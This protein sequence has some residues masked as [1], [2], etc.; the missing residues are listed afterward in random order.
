MREQV[1]QQLIDLNRGFYRGF[2]APFAATRLR[3]QPGVRRAVELI[4]RDA[5]VLDLGCGTGELASALRRA[6]HT[7]GYV[8]IDA[9]AELLAIAR[10]RHPTLADR[11]RED[12]L[13]SPGWES[14]LV[15]PFARITAFAVLHHIPSERLRSEVARSIGELLTPGGM[16]ILSVWN[17]N[18]S[19]RLRAR[20]V[21]WPRVGLTPADVD[22]GDAL[23]GW[24]QGGS[25]VRYVH[26]FGPHE[27]DGLAASAGLT[28]VDRYDSDGEGGRLGH[29]QV[30]RDPDF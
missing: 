11:F 16:V 12:D 30:W 6:G 9:S 5:D 10:S 27:L 17:F 13:A 29:Y 19:E 4:P 2:A 22:P 1:V 14:R 24:R 28:V 8:G 26:A 18:A 20:V 3:L 15:G 7:G 21:P 25:G 23:I